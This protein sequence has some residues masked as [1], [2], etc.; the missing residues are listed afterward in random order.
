MRESRG[1]AVRD[2]GMS[3]AESSCIL[4]QEEPG[5]VLGSNYAVADIS[6][7]NLGLSDTLGRLPALS[8][9]HEV[10]GSYSTLPT[11]LVLIA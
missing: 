5:T 1:P 4:V 3:V 2:V 11:Y 8:T 10:R 6:I 9:Q 7:F